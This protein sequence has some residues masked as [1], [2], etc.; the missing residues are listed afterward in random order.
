MTKTSRVQFVTA[1]AVPL[2]AATLRCG[3]GYAD[4]PPV[5]DSGA[6][7]RSLSPAKTA[8]R[9][10]EV[11]ARN[12]QPAAAG[13]GSGKVNL[14]IRF[15]NDSNQLTPAAHAQLEQLGAALNSPA[16]AHARFQ[17]AGHTSATGDPKHNQQLSENRARAVR[18]YLLQHF[19]I[20]PER[21][22]ATGF[23]SSRPLSQ[24]APTAVQQRRVE[25]STLPSP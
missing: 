6:I 1:L 20:A 15:G 19:A 8:T 13:G 11:E 21:I 4:Q 10:F 14:D 16:L 12:T 5:I 23:G 7:V 24:Y 22:E 9:G 17:I 18:T 2:L 25:I 3:A